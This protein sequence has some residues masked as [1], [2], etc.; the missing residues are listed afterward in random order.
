MPRASRTSQALWDAAVAAFG[1]V[2]IWVNN[3]GYART[4]ARFADTTPQQI[5][6]MV[7]ANVIGSMNA[8]QVA[9]RRHEAPGRRQAST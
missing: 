6:A 3:A 2:D 7:R 8:A 9:H 1:R 5:E 4:G